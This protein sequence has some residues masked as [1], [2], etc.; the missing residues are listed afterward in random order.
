MDKVKVYEYTE[1]KIILHSKLL[2]IDDEFSFIS[3]VNL[4]KRSFFHDLENGVVINDNKFTMQMDSLYN[5]YLK[6]SK[7]L[8]EQ[9]KIKFWK[10]MIINVFDKAL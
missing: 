4:N 3:S 5:D 7:Q 9:Q 2:M 1:P 8:T 10:K 6:N